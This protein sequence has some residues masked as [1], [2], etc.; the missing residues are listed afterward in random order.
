MKSQ[1]LFIKFLLVTSFIYSQD[2]N[3]KFINESESNKRVKIFDNYKDLVLNVED[4]LISLKKTGNL[5]AEVKSFIMV[6]LRARPPIGFFFQPQG[7][8][9]P[10]TLDVKTNLIALSDEKFPKINDELNSKKS[11][12]Y[13][14]IYIPI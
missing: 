6:D 3:L 12:T 9:S 10:L 11:I 14:F 2:Y 1:L 5:E 13:F 7:S 8:V 4:T